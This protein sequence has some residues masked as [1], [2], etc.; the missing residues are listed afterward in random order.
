M[1][2]VV[3]RHLFNLLGFEIKKIQNNQWNGYQRNSQEGAVV[4]IKSLNFNPDFI[5]D[6]GAAFGDVTRILKRHFPNS[7]VILIEALSEYESTLRIVKKELSDTDYII[8]AVGSNEG[9]ITF[10]VHPDLVGS[11]LMNETEG[12]E[13]DGIPRTVPCT[14]LDAIKNKYQLNGKGILK[15][16]VQGAELEV[17]KGASDILKNIEVIFMEVSLLGLFVNGPQLSDVVDFMKKL[18]FVCYDIY[19]NQYRPLDGAACMIDM[20]FVKEDGFFRKFHHYA[21]KEQRK[22]QN[23]YMKKS[24]RLK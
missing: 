12:K 10:N 8:T 2:R 23:E 1:I 7:K 17:L 19:G 18:G 13:A 6:I 15:I 14:T 3:I 24:L 16:D 20:V 4:N 11:S 9:S 21:T 5:I 22:Q